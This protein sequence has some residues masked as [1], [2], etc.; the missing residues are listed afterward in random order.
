MP[1]NATEVHSGEGKSSADTSSLQ[2]QARQE[3]EM[4]WRSA[5]K[6]TYE[7]GLELGRVCCK[8][9]KE[10][11]A[12]GQKGKGLLPI[13]EEVNLPVS[14]AYWWMDRYEERNTN[15]KPGS[16][17]EE[18]PLPPLIDAL[19]RFAWRQAGFTVIYAQNHEFH[20]PMTQAEQEVMAVYAEIQNI[21]QQKI[22]N[23]NS[24]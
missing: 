21:C 10:F 18:K 9:R 1:K 8:W 24:I 19:A 20:T 7:E 17:K 22:Q 23:P 12:Q 13:L 14:T 4:A 11:G 2:F 3:I 6:M 15:K 5:G 16:E